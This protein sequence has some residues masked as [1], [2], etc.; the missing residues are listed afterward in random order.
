M[1]KI[2]RVYDNGG[3]TADRYTVVLAKRGYEMANPA[4]HPMLSMS[5]YPNHP[6]GVSMFGEG[7]IG[8]HLGKRIKF[9]DLPENVRH[10]AL[11]RLASG[12]SV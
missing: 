12:E 7:R 11:E 6:Q 1:N 9:Y 4:H 2:I 8:R 3:A 5:E 10:H